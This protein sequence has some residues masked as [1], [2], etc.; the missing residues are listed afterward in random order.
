MEGYIEREKE[1]VEKL[2]RLES[3]PLKSDIDYSTIKISFS[4]SCSKAK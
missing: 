3:I 4:R 1:H 2:K